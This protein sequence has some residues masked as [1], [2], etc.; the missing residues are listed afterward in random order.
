MEHISK[1]LETLPTA[2]AAA[3]ATR[4]LHSAKI[5]WG[6]HTFNEPKLVELQAACQQFCDE[7]K[8]GYPPRWLSILG[9]S[10]TGKSHM[11]KKAYRWVLDFGSAYTHE[12]GARL[13]H[14]CKRVDWRN[15]ATNIRNGDW[16]YVDELKSVWFLFI[17]DLGAEHKGGTG[18]VQSALEAIIDA[19]MGKWTLITSN[20]G[21]QAIAD[22]IDPRVAS[23]MKRVGNSIVFIKDV[24]DY[25]ERK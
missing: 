4:E 13:F 7:I 25:Y 21:R 17:D 3:P 23:R 14:R 18:I 16:N 22:E 1:Y 10:G 6:F 11:A 9:K 15:A 8:S 12:T 5:D 2:A 19:R 20:L 24:A